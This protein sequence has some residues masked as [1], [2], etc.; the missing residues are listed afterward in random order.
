[1]CL[2]QRQSLVNLDVLLDAQA[3]SIGLYGHIV[4][5]HV[6]TQRDGTH[7]VKDTFCV[8]L[9]RHGAYDDIGIG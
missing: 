2:E 6:V 4:E 9:P 1:M 3:F 8:C 7:P 5:H